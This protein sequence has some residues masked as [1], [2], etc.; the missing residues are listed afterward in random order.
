MAD[1][2]PLSR[3][4]GSSEAADR[5]GVITCTV[6][7][8]VAL[9]LTVAAIVG[10]V[11][12]GSPETPADAGAGESDST[13][14]LWVIIG[15]SAAI[16]AGS[17][18]LL[19]RARRAAEAEPARRAVSRPVVRAAVD[20]DPAETGTDPH[21]SP[22][23]DETVE[24]ILLRGGIGVLTGTGGAMALVALATLLMAEGYDTGAWV[25]IGFAGAI[26]LAMV[27]I[28]E[29]FLRGLKRE[30][31]SAEDSEEPAEE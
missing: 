19:I 16:I 12:M 25:C 9:A 15:V 11:D 14:W 7:W 20:R 23:P 5:A 29:F 28:P 30:A 2:N 31:S 13:W 27:V 1:R 10:L 26:T 6:V 8:L 22:V 17:I 3:L 21:G 24:R 4:M 18:P